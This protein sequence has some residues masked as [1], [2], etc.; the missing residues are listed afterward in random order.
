MSIESMTN[1]QITMVAS[2]MRTDKNKT[3][4]VESLPGKTSNKTDEKHAL[5]SFLTQLRVERGHLKV[6]TFLEGIDIPFSANYYRDIEA[7]RKYLSI[8]SAVELHNSLGIEPS[9]KSSFDYFWHYFK[10]LLPSDMHE[11][12]FGKGIETRDLSSRLELRDHDSKILRRALSLSRYERE[13]IISDEIIRGFK[14]NFDLWPL[15]TYLYMVDTASVAEIKQVCHQLDIA[16]DSRVVEFLSL[17]AK[18][19]NHE[20]APFIRLAPT[21]RMPRTPESINLK[22]KFMCYETEKSLSKPEKSE[23][24]DIDGTFKFSAMVTLKSPEIEQIQDRLVDL[25]SAIEVHTK[26]GRQL[27]DENAHPYFLELI[28]SGRP[29]YDGRTAR[30]PSGFKKPE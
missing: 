3:K 27:E 9:S 16:F 6:S 12:L 4:H 10:D 1:Q 17:V 20:E 15:M 7:G 18:E 2:G 13:F 25:F 23:Y 8:D 11:M 28:I 19:R 14:N 26:S 21:L 24:F 30:K 29:E 22:D 5:G